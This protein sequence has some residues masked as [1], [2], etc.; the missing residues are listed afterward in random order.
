MKKTLYFE[1]VGW[2]GAEISKATIGNCRI[3]TAFHL[4]DGRAVYLEILGVEVTKNTAPV[5]KAFAPYAGYVD[6]CHYITDEVPNDDSNKYRI[7]VPKTSFHFDKESI[8]SLVNE[9]GASFDE[10]MV[11]PDLGGYRVFRNNAAAYNF[12]DAFEFDPALTEKR[13]A[14][15]NAVYEWEK[16]ERLEDR[17]NH[18]GKFV[19][20]P[21]GNCYPNF[22][23]WVDQDEPEK[24]HLI[25]RYNGYSRRWEIDATKD[26][27]K[28]TMVET[29]R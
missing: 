21:S 18:G 2:S 29:A 4:E 6:H 11:V 24:L 23:L 25:R 1:G 15:Y 26:D 8:L 28:E 3:R 22:S 5:L 7:Q 12:G 10:I 14:I 17:M 20:S 16:A 19:H 27:W 13:E 9:M